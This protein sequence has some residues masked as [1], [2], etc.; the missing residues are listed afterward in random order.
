MSD[1]S[2]FRVAKVLQTATSKLLKEGVKPT[3]VL[4]A[5][6]MNI[7]AFTAFLVSKNR[8]D[9]DNDVT[10]NGVDELAS[11]I[12]QEVSTFLLLNGFPSGLN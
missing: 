10:E 8:I 5:Y 4:D 2:V 3:D 11:R 6:L 9:F 7:A 12:R 1:E